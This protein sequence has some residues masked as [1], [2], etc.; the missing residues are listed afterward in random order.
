MA[1][2]DELRANWNYPTAIRFGAGRIA[3]LAEACRAAGMRRPLLVT[4]PGLAALPMI[5]EAAA[6]LRAAG[7]DVAVF[8][9]LRGN[10][11]ARNV[12]D[13]VAALRAG[14]HD[15]VVAFG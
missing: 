15:G 10:P 2:L 6:A 4:D 9:K 12:E 1:S 5:A 11:V 14:G 7:L 13:G 8:S 3:E